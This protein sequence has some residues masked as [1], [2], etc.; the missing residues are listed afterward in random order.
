MMILVSRKV[1]GYPH[2]SMLTD[3][4]HHSPS[5]ST[6]GILQTTPPSRRQIFSN[7]GTTRTKVCR[8]RLLASGL[9]LIER[10][11]ICSEE[12][13]ITAFFQMASDS[14]ITSLSL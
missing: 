10:R 11:R 5:Y 1:L 6:T 2:N 4:L 14:R 3:E 13:F 8:G 12:I 9:S 7:Q